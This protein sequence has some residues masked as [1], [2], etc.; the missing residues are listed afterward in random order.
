[1][2]IH[3]ISHGMLHSLYKSPWYS[4]ESILHWH[5]AYRCFPSLFPRAGHIDMTCSF[6]RSTQ[7]SHV[8][9]KHPLQSWTGWRRQMAF[10][11]PSPIRQ[12][13]WLRQK[14][15]YRQQTFASR[16]LIPGFDARLDL[17][18][19]DR[20]L[21]EMVFCWM[22]HWNLS[23]CLIGWLFQSELSIGCHLEDI[24]GPEFID[25]QSYN[26]HRPHNYFIYIRKLDGLSS[27][28]RLGACNSGWFDGSRLL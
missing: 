2:E 25:K 28:R 9:P 23:K 11:S 26:G 21:I 10:F 22:I 13:R 12:T 17:R 3:D 8:M 4:I 20:C 7:Q 6:P 15:F 16:R 18:W 5:P 24:L 27:W 1:M 14:V 19:F